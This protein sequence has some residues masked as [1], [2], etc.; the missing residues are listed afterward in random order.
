MRI[1]ALRLGT[2]VDHCMSYRMPWAFV[3]LQAGKSVS[4]QAQTAALGASIVKL[5]PLD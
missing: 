4:A 1:C 2:L 3:L 5:E